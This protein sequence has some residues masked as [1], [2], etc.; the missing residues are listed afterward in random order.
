MAKR[1]HSDRVLFVTTLALVMFGLVMVFSSSAVLSSE[2]FGNAYMFLLRQLAWAAA[3]LVVMLVVMRVD[4]RRLRHPAFIFLV[5]SVTL[6][7]L[8]AVL[9]MDVTQ[10]THRWFRVGS[11]SFQPSELAKPVLVLFL[12]WWLE[13]RS[14]SVNDFFYTLLPAAM[15]VGAA[16]ALVLKGP[17]LGTAAAILLTAGGLFFLAGLHLKYFAG[18]ALAAIPEIGRAHV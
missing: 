13:R 11:F 10:K 8:V 3:G 6:A 15:V 18:L 5:L 12:A 4:Y 7:L 2:Q 9:F 16:V 17:D 1:L 14:R